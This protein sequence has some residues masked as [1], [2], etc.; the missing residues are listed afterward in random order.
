MSVSE[1]LYREK[2]R[3]HGRDRILLQ[4]AENFQRENKSNGKGNQI[5]IPSVALPMW[6]E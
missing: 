4:I 1:R 2:N 5:V 3:P 6:S